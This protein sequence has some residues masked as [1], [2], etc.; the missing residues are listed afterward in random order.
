M[1]EPSEYLKAGVAAVQTLHA[2]RWQWNVEH[3]PTRVWR[4][5]TTRDEA[6]QWMSATVSIDPTVGGQLTID[7]GG[8]SGPK[9]CVIVEMEH[10]RVLVHTWPMPPHPDEPG[11]NITLVRWTITATT[12][13]AHIGFTHSGL[14]PQETEG[15]GGGWL[16]FLDQF[17]AVLDGRPLLPP[18]EHT[19]L[20]T[21]M[22]DSWKQQLPTR[23]P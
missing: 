19:A 3:S 10:E 18:D 9:D 7:W 14:N 5:I 23:S 16:G 13:G 6:S 11:R 2:L 12:S 20:V 21:P 22:I 1:P 17:H 8:K 15:L 4:A